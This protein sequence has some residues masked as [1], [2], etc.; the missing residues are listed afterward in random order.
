MQQPKAG[1][2]APGKRQTT[3]LLAPEA[4][5]SVLAESAAGQHQRIGYSP[6]GHRIAQER[7]QSRTGFNG[8]LLE[9]QGWYHLGNGHRVYNPALRRFHSADRLSPFGEGGLNAYAYCLGD[10]VNHVDP[11][12]CAAN[13]LQVATLI[14]IGIGMAAGAYGLLGP[15]LFQAASKATGTALA[16]SGAK[17]LFSAYTSHV[18]VLLGRYAA[19]QPS[20]AGPMLGGL[21]A[22]ASIAGLATLPVAAASAVK[23]IQHPMEAK[24]E[25]MK[26]AA[27]LGL[28]VL[29]VKGFLVP[30]VPKL[31]TS[32]WGSRL[33]KIVHGRR[34]VKA[35][36]EKHDLM[37]RASSLDDVGGQLTRSGATPPA[38]RSPTPSM[39]PPP[40]PPPPLPRSSPPMSA[41]IRRGGERGTRPG[42]IE[43]AFIVSV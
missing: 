19:L 4:H 32:K 43:I 41:Q 22:A 29:P 42:K 17:G 2:G 35:A 21:D 15:A 13:I 16:K 30:S 8:Q 23:D 7:T 31:A 25:I 38:L 1:T 36:W 11:T 5:G 40:S 33:A 6:Y 14:G 20:I 9:P 28:F 34:S 39:S 18:N 12:G 27:V 3:F 10:P 26:A 24:W 37:R